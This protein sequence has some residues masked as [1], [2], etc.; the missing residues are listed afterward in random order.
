MKRWSL[1]MVVLILAVVVAACGNGNSKNN[2]A[3]GNKGADKGNNAEQTN[4]GKSNDAEVKTKDTLT[5]VWLPNESG[6]NMKEARDEIGALVE[7]ASGKKVEHKVTTDYIIAV[8]S[9]ANGTADIGYFG[10]Q[11][12]VEANAKN[13]KVQPLVTNAGKSGTLEDAMYYSWLA[14]NKGEESGYAAGDSFAI[15]NIKGKKFSFVSNS[16]TSGFKVPTAGIISYFKDNHAMADLTADDLVEGGKDKFFSQVLFGG[17]HQ[18]SAVNLMSGKVD[19]AA[20]CNTCVVNYVEL[21]A[22]EENAVGSTY[23]VKADA[24]APFNTVA[25]K[26]F[27]VISST[28]VLNQPFIVNTDTVSAEHI[29]L[30]T[31]AFESDETTN[32]PK[33]FV[34]EDSEFSGMFKKDGETRFLKVEDAWFNPI[35]ELTGGAAK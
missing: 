10:P 25:G 28:P 33:I 3:G 5:I 2:T 27:A 13:D 24:E 32:N 6:G 15:D 8:E 17:S 1:M 20:F 31:D 4:A 9:I 19:V 7:K 29:K 22:G 16:S 14:V 23:K 21:A 18:G 35:R 34:P 12:Y 26:E 30:I 11:A